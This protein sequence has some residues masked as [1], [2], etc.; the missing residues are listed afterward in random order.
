M[1]LEDISIHA[2]I[3]EHNLKTEKGIPLDFKQHHFLFEPYSDFSPEQVI[4]KAAQIG[5]SV[6]AINKTF[7]VAKKK[8]LDIIYT[9]PTD[10]D[11]QVFVS[12]K[13]NRII[14]NNEILREY[15]KDKDTVEQKKVGKSMIYFRGTFTKRAAISVTSDLNI[16][17]EEDFSDQEIISDYDSRLQHSSY[18]WNWHFGHP[19]TLGVGV[20]KYWDKSDQKHW[21]VV[22]PHCSKEQYLSFPDSICVERQEYVCKSCNNLLDNQT[23]INGRWVK[24]YKNKRYSGYWIPLLLAPWTSAS[25]ILQKQKDH[26]EEFFYNRI[27]GLPYIGSGNKVSEDDILG[28]LTNE[29]NNQEGKIVIGVDTG[30]YLR[31]V[32]GNEDGI[33]FYGQTKKYK[34]IERLLN[35]W[36]GSVAVFDQGGDIIGVRELREKYPGR[37]YL[38]HYREDRKTLT[39]VRWGNKD[40][41]GSVL[42][43]RNRLIQLLIDEFKS[44]RI[45]INGIRSDWL[46]YWDHWNN[47]YRVAKED[48]LHVIKYKWMRAGRDDY[49]HAT[50]YWRVGMSRFCAGEGMIFSATPPEKFKTA[51]VIGVDGRM[52]NVLAQPTKEVNIDWGI[53]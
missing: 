22:C 16:H 32:V 23:R 39:L 42:V 31:Y 15:T 1:K 11:V 46:E 35:R 21:F 36:K 26:T 14:A 20:S 6:L 9:M 17:D 28:C 34:D 52:L 18:K 49:V 47:I 8:G 38:C 29:T 25:F 43:D 4:M 33:F 41:S 5:F 53:N 12:G 2:W 13:V 3:Q 48:S 51:P 30:I 24:K 27:L 7:W 40:E 50:V 44:R 37:V 45:S 19:S 10:S